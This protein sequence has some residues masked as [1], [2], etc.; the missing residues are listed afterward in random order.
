MK[1]RNKTLSKRE[2]FSNYSVKRKGED[3]RFESFYERDEHCEEWYVRVGDGGVY[4]NVCTSVSREIYAEYVSRRVRS[5]IIIFTLVI[6][7]LSL[8]GSQKVKSRKTFIYSDA[9]NDVENAG[10]NI[11]RRKSKGLKSRSSS[12]GLG[13]PGKKK[14]GLRNCLLYTSPSPRDGLLSRMPSSA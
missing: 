5:L 1:G 3:A 9:E 11:R 8:P 12:R 14:G 10:A 13:K 7:S 6:I 2:I 4:S